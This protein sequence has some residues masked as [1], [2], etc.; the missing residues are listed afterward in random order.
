LYLLLG[1][2]DIYGSNY[3]GGNDGICKTKKQ[4]ENV[5]IK[6]QKE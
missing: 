4:A 5:L 3:I 6:P 1:K 2:N